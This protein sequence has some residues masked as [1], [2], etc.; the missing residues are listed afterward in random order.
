MTHTIT[1]SLPEELLE[2]VDARVRLQH[3]DRSRTVQELL[4]KGLLHDENPHAGNSLDELLACAAGPS[5]ADEMSD[6]EL[7]DFAEAE[8]KAHRAEKRQAAA[9]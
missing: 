3:T 4:E 9:G 5:P 1:V 7:A 6:D 8:V 2:R